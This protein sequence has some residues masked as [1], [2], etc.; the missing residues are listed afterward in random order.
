VRPTFAIRAPR[1]DEAGALTELAMRAKASWGYDREFLQACRAELTVTAEKLA[2]WRF[3]V[4]DADG[5]L[6][7]MIA[8]SDS[9]D[10]AEVEDFFVAPEA[11][12]EGIGRALMD[13][14]QDECRARGY[15][16]IGVDADPNA[17]AIYLRLGF[18][19][20]GRSPSGSIPGR[21]LPRMERRLL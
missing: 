21:W 12:G 18:H 14:F 19:T 9:E 17:E 16:R 10:H 11:Q 20:V 7:G 2:G 1:A 6:A 3:W 15:A 4:A 5:H 8:L 13:A